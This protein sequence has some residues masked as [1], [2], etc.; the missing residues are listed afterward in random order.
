M[1][2]RHHKKR[3]QRINVVANHQI[4]FPQVR[5]LSD[6]GEMM[7]VMSIKDAQYKAHAVGEDLVLVTPKADPPIVKIIDLAKFKYQQK[8]KKAE[9]RKKAKRQETKGVRLTPF[10]GEGDFQT[11]L[12]KIVKF[13]EQGHKV[14]I[15]IAFVKGRQITKKEFGYRNFERIFEHTADIAVVEI[16]PKAIGKKIMT[17][18]MPV[19][20]GG[21]KAAKED[22]NNEEIQTKKPQGSSKKV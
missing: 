21:S 16:Q 13:L 4:R 19:K 18:L 12:K 17:Q 15:E 1:I 7:G 8:Q 2:R 5:V 11:R 6:K 10:I 22:I 3:Q 9:G 14:R 20:K